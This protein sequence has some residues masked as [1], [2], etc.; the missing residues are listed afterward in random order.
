ME[1]RFKIC[2]LLM[3][4]VSLLLGSCSNTKF[5]AGDQLLYTGSTRIFIADSGKFRDTRTKQLSESVTAYK[6]NNSVGGK[7]LLLPVGLWIY[8]YRKPAENK[9]PGWL[10][11]TL[12]KE[13]VLISTVNPELRCKKLESE[14]FGN[15]YFTSRVW[16]EIDTSAKNSRKAGIKYF[17]NTGRQFRYNKIIFADPVDAVD[18]LI[19]RSQGSIAIKPGD[20]FKLEAIKSETSVI[21]NRILDAGY[22]FFNQSHLKYTADTTGEPGKID[23]R[24]GKTEGIPENALK[25]YY[26]DD[27]TVRISGG[28]DSLF[29]AEPFIM[30]AGGIKIIS[31]GMK[32]RP[33]V[34]TR[35][36]Y[37]RKGDAYSASGHRQT[38]THLNS[39]GIFKFINIKYQPDSDTL[40]SGLDMVIDLTPMKDISLDLEGN[41]VTK[42]TGFSG[43]GFAA[44]LSQG[45]LAGGANK[46]QL[47]LNGGF[48][49]QWTNKSGNTLGTTSYSAGLSGSV[50]FPRL[51]L[52]E[53]WLNDEKFNLP[54][55]SVTLGF[56]F[57][58]KIQ[59]YRMSS[60]NLGFGYQW[61]K[62]ERITHSFYPV[63]VNSIDLLKTTPEFDSILAANPY[64]RKSFEEQFIVGMKYDFI[65]DNS[66]SGKT[67]GFY[68]SSGI[69]S[70]GNML[71]LIKR[72]TPEEED[73]PY[74]VAGSVY[75]QFIKLTSDIRYYRNF[76]NNTFVTRF[77]TGVG[78]PYTNS[79]VMPYVE[80]FYSGGSNSIRA[81]VAR[82]LGPGNLKLP[83]DADIKDQTGDIK[84]EGNMEYRFKISKVMRG[85]LFIDAG[86]VWLL[87]PDET[88][89]GAEFRFSTFADQLALGTG[90]GI[91]FDFDFFVLR[92]DLGFPLRTPYET[93]GSNWLGSYHDIINGMVFNLAIGYPF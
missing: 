43:P 90:L 88:R 37:F 52:P 92:T 28:S 20:V 73:R 79:V 51:I 45:N 47:K 25:K 1:C 57:L 30:E 53:G 72:T 63:F 26:I 64:I 59:Y 49:W 33:E 7:R 40:S 44:T 68:F 67:N 9:K 36:I 69:S 24:I 35:C 19:R 82:T 6:P 81:F 55:T 46:L 56:E 39:Y 34:M 38:I 83:E 50:I 32:F 18:T 10:Y 60:V 31:T 3:G 41:V 29:A 12:A 84:L 62:P 76:L 5:L 80:Q 17:I 8:N 15:G 91:R 23:L 89:P 86:N 42:S 58:N 78:V 71:D 66:T 11:R 74:T 54:K 65:Y 21:T 16:S 48:E 27:I 75:S 93:D 13:P 22:F 4:A 85:A 2:Y 87:N 77:Y 61:R 14:M 70:G